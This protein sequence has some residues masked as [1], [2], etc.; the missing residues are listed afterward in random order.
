MNKTTFRDLLKQYFPPEALAM[1]ACRVVSEILW[2][3][4]QYFGLGFLDNVE[5]YYS[6]EQFH[7]VLQEYSE[8]ICELEQ[9]RYQPTEDWCTTRLLDPLFAFHPTVKLAVGKGIAST[10]FKA[11]THCSMIQ[12]S[13]YWTLWGK[14]EDDEE[15]QSKP[16]AFF[17]QPIFSNLHLGMAILRSNDLFLRDKYQ[18]FME[19]LDC[20]EFNDFSRNTYFDMNVIRVILRG[21]LFP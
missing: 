16:I 18:C 8:I 14:V 7:K 2:F 4:H 3:Q 19:C 6:M 20:P 17:P 11:W 21:Y 5:M 10:G 13:N 9:C 12:Q 15:Y 1:N